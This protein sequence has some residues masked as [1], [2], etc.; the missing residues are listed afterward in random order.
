VT[1]QL[2]RVLAD[3]VSDLDPAV[4]PMPALRQRVRA[5][6]RRRAGL[7]AIA[8]VAFVGL[9]G[10]GWALRPERE[11]TTLVVSDGEVRL[12]DHV[13]LTDVPEWVDHVDAVSVD[14]TPAQRLFGYREQIFELAD[15]SSERSIKILVD[16]GDPFDPHVASFVREGARGQ[17]DGDVV[18]FDAPDAMVIG[19]PTPGVVVTVAGGTL[20]EARRVYDGLVATRE[21]EPIPDVVVAAGGLAKVTATFPNG[22]PWDVRVTT[23]EPGDTAVADPDG[24]CV[25]VRTY[26]SGVACM[27]A[28]GDVPSVQQFAGFANGVDPELMAIRTADRAVLV[29]VHRESGAVDEA[30]TGG[31]APAAGRVAVVDAPPSGPDSIVSID[32]LDADERVIGT[33]QI[34]NG[35]VVPP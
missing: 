17:I 19:T 12:T 35:A 2:D 22:V 3:W 20:D 33:V 9:A 13:T 24:H 7:A 31:L 14:V 30:I 6:R 5:R 10:I 28:P 32:L 25:V 8:A 4:P 16:A 21:E 23:P 11:P 1:D 29:R 27:G 18:L 26:T 15:T 34:E